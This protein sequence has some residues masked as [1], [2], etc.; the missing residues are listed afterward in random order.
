MDKSLLECNEEVFLPDD[1]MVG[2]YHLTS[3]EYTYLFI[4]TA[5]VLDTHRYV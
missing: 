5:Y 1:N 2:V 3:Y 4:F